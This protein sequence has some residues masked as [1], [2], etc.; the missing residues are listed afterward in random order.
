[1][2]RFLFAVAV[3]ALSA[4]AAL[5]DGQPPT[6]MPTPAAPIITAAPVV[7]TGPVQPARRGLF[8]RLRN[9]NTMTYSSAPVMTA[10]TM[11]GSAAPMPSIAPQPQP[12]PM[13][14]TRNGAAMMTGP[15]VQASGN[16]PPGT[17]TT[18]DGSTIQV[19]GTQGMMQT[20]SMAPTRVR[21]G[22]FGRLRYSY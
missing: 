12:M 7:T 6:G 21:R 2:K 19:G 11:G 10:P 13:P 17:Y 5:A 8:A 22:L 3:V 9:R 14:G 18:A 16:L 4:A 20:T 1:M 15:V